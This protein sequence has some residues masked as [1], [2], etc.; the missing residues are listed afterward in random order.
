MQRRALEVPQMDTTNHVALVT[1]GGS[2][3]GLAIARRL[4]DDGNTVIIAGRS[5][6]RLERARDQLPAL[7]AVPFDVSDEAQIRHALDGIAGG[8]GRLTLLVNSAG[9]LGGYDFVDD[10]GAGPRMDEEVTTNLLGLLRVTRLALP[11]LLAQPAAAVVNVSSVLAYA[12]TPGSAVYSATKAA[13]HSFTRSL[14]VRLAGTPVRV[15]EVFPPLVDTDMVRGLDVPKVAPEV[16]AGAVMHGLRRDRHEV[17]VGG[18]RAVHI[19]SRISPGRAESAVR[20]AVTP[21]SVPLHA[22]GDPPR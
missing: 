14:R 8:F 20:R 2:G 9:V 22:G 15:F 18:S 7:H 21:R 17:R 5:P 3:I 6:E 11:L 10:R 13:V 16:V 19:L 4:L 1:G 12:G